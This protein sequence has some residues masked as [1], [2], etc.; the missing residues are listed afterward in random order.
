MR[1]PLRGLA[2][3]AFLSTMLMTVPSV[4]RARAQASQH[5]TEPFPQPA[6]HMPSVDGMGQTTRDPRIIEQRAGMMRA[7]NS[8]RQKHIVE[9][10]ARLLQLATELKSDVDKSSKDQLSLDVVRKAEEIE[11]LAHNV[12][13]RMKG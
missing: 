9:D 11:R 12:K 5:Q 6:T 7:L 13:E 4:G 8:D 10:T 2:I 3:A 1:I